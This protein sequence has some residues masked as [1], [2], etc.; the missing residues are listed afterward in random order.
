MLLIHSVQLV[1]S[2]AARRDRSRQHG[3]G[4]IIMVR[5]N[6]L[7]DEIDTTAVSIAEVSEVVANKL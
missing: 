3:G 2:V 1:T 5:E 6:I 4:V 7:F